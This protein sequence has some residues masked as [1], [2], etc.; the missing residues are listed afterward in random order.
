MLY[1][2]WNAH[3]SPYCS[4]LAGAVAHTVSSQ[5]SLLMTQSWVSKLARL[6]LMSMTESF[7][8]LV[9]FYQSKKGQIYARRYIYGDHQWFYNMSVSE[10][11]SVGG[12]D[13]PLKS[14]L[15]PEKFLLNPN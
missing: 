11:S 10:R 7:E 13:F 4:L 8:R 3:S 12:L 2:L 5:G 9:T 6:S 1:N 14:E 15:L